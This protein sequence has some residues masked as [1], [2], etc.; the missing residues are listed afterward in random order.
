MKKT[1]S[2]NPIYFFIGL[3]IASVLIS[4]RAIGILIPVAGLLGIFFVMGKENEESTSFYWF[5]FLSIALLGIASLFW[6]VDIEDS[7]NRLKK[8]LPLLLGGTLFLTFGKT[9]ISNLKKRDANSTLKFLSYACGLGLIFIIIEL[10][11][12]APVYHLFHQDETEPIYMSVYNRSLLVLFFLTVPLIV[13][14]LKTGKPSEAFAL[15]VILFFT[16]FLSESQSAQIGCFLAVFTYGSHYLLKNK[17]VALTAIAFVFVFTTL[18]LAAPII[19]NS[20]PTFL[21]DVIRSG[22]PMNRLEIWDFV[23]RAVQS[24][25]FIGHGI[26]TVKSYQFDTQRLYHPDSTV[27]HPHNMYLQIWFE[28]GLL[29]VLTTVAI[30]IAMFSKIIKMT[31]PHQ[32]MLMTLLIPYLAIAAVSY[33]LWQSWWIGLTFFLIVYLYFLRKSVLR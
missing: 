1:L 15:T 7:G 17:L 23:S 24:Q 2:Y 12:D 22:Y 5:I 31:L 13:A 10:F 32:Q 28:F 14:C 27:L 30:T 25:P 6:S 26:E 11:F 16:C 3:I 20:E 19:F 21:L 18:P 29:G 9:Y 4:S 33:G 8:L